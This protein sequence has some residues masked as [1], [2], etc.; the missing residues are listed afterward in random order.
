[1]KVNV[2]AALD[3]HRV[4]LFLG[5]LG[6]HAESVEYRRV[7]FAQQHHQWAGVG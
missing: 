2:A 6:R 5:T 4:T 3:N 7:V 1:M